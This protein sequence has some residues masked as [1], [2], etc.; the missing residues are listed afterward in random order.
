MRKN[1]TIKTFIREKKN[2]LPTPHFIN[3][4]QT[5][6]AAKIIL[7]NIFKYI[8][9]KSMYTKTQDLRFRALDSPNISTHLQC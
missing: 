4:E 2:E 8:D 5:H 3:R 7:Q 6:E 1:N 9:Q